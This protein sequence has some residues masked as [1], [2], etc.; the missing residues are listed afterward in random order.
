M[1]TSLFSADIWVDYF[2]SIFYETS[3]LTVALITFGIQ[4]F[5]LLVSIVAIQASIRSSFLHQICSGRSWC[6]CYF[7]RWS[8]TE[9]SNRWCLFWKK[10]EKDTA[11]NFTLFWNLTYPKIKS[12][13]SSLELEQIPNLAIV[14]LTVYRTSSRIYWAYL[15]AILRQPQSRSCVISLCCC[16]NC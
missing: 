9:S 3:S 16:L 12:K 8:Q 5:L 4:L 2:R 13:S 1:R 15:L 7:L 14:Q 11:V 10:D 6:K